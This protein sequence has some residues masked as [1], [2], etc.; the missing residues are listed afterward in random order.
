MRRRNAVPPCRKWSIYPCYES[1]ES[2]VRISSHPPTTVPVAGIYPPSQHRKPAQSHALCGSA[3]LSCCCFGAS[4][5]QAPSVRQ[6][7][8]DHIPIQRHFPQIST[9][10]FLFRIA[11]SFDG[12]SPVPLRTPKTKRNMLSR[13]RFAIVIAPALVSFGRQAYG[14]AAPV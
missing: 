7:Q 13:L 5:K 9:Q 4:G 12:L 10:I 1:L 6:I 8:L 3:G 14:Q 2:W 11:A